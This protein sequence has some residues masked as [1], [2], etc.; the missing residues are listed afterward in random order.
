MWK[1][2]KCSTI[3]EG[4]ANF[5]EMCGAPRPKAA[6]GQERVM[7]EPARPEAHEQPYVPPTPEK[8][9]PRGKKR[10]LMPVAIVLAVA[11][12]VC[13]GVAFM[14]LQY[15]K[16]DGYARQGQWK[17]AYQTFERISWYRDSDRRAQEAAALAAGGAENTGAENEIDGNEAQ[18]AGNLTLAVPDFAT[19][20]PV[21]ITVTPIASEEP[22]VSAEPIASAEPAPT[23]EIS[24]A[25]PEYGVGTALTREEA[26]NDVQVG[27]V[28]QTVNVE[29]TD[30]S[31][32]AGSKHSV[33]LKQD[34][35]VL[36]AGD[37]GHGQCDVAAWRN[38]VAVS[39]GNQHT[40]GLKSDGTVLAVGDNGYGQCN[41]TAWNDI[42]EISAGGFYTLG[43]KSDGTVV[44][45]GMNLYGQCDVDTWSGI[46]SVSAGYWHTVGLR[47]DG[48][49]VAAGYNEWGQCNVSDWSNI[50]KVSA[51]RS[52]TVA[53]RADGSV[54]A[55]GDNEYGQCD[56]S[57][58]TDIVS[59]KAGVAYTV[60][61]KSDGTLVTAGYHGED[62][63]CNVG[64][65][66]GISAIAVGGYHTLGVDGDGG[67]VAT[68]WDGN[69]ACNV[70]AWRLGD[71][72]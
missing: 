23:G 57:G 2:V 24:A 70:S 31:I 51:G 32:A 5:C 55:A 1:C 53:L 13:L 15:R 36:A 45:A 7:R 66:S 40:V 3:N 58:W 18:D 33:G 9:A 4:E 17:A 25:L 60:G 59:V 46:K 26:Q 42:A 68:G 10:W 65:W 71:A 8:R 64:E 48:S 12:I 54:V 41:V 21:E 35:T 27:A 47:A 20:G 6:L 11:I 56:V 62:G 67:A 44:A 50:V 49:V 16:A 72:E 19:R 14:E 30:G 39:A 37:N 28:S 43:V 29:I 69:G 63:R 34:G 61:L 38:I 52:H 22:A